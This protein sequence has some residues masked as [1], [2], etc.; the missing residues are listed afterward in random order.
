MISNEFAIWKAA[1]RWADEKCRQNAIE[2]SAE[3]RRSALGPA[4]FKIRFPLI[5][6]EGFTRSIVPSGILIIEEFVAVY[7]FHCH[8]NLRNVPGFYPMK[9]PWNGRI[10]DWNKSHGNRGTLALEIKKFSKFA[11]EKVGSF[12]K[13]EVEVFVN[14]LP[15]KIFGEITEKWMVFGIWCT[16]RK[17]DGVWSCKCSST[18]R[19]VSQKN[20]TEDLTRNYD[21]VF[22][23]KLPCWRFTFI[24]FTEL[25]NPSR[26]LYDKNEDKVTLA[27]D[28]TVE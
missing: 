26:G 25:M 14:G 19:I 8:A 16:A 13:S 17:E 5:S 7:Q 10:S 20:G 27:I 21:R 18:L 1:L 23:N 24:T 4:L 3:N 9:F 2:C 11:R 28:F 12:R 15:W 22:N 6:S